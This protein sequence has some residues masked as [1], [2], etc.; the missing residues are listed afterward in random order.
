M[1][2]KDIKL[3]PFWKRWFC[4][5]EPISA[6]GMKGFFGLT[7]CRKCG[8]WGNIPKEGMT[9]STIKLPTIVIKHK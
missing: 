7:Q 1:R 4:K 9:V 8:E 5:H 6:Y 2:Y 3:Q